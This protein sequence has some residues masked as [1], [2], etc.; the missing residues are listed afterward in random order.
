MGEF[1]GVWIGSQYSCYWEREHGETS[2][3]SPEGAPGPSLPSPVSLAATA[4]SL[5]PAI[6]LPP[7][8]PVFGG[9]ASLVPFW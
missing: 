7:P 2:A 4:W 8:S 5:P 6:R 3:P 1:Y 9:M